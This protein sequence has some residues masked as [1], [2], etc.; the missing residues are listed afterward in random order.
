MHNPHDTRIKTYKGT[1][2]NCTK[3]KTRRCCDIKNARKRESTCGCDSKKRKI[4]QA[5]NI[6]RCTKR[7]LKIFLQRD[8]PAGI[9]PVRTKSANKLCMPE[10]SFWKSHS[11]KPHAE[12]E[13]GKLQFQNL[14]TNIN[15][16]SQIINFMLNKSGN[17]RGKDKWK[18]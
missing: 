8:E 4:F 9:N 1:I 11:W 5:K 13:P 7:T 17:T 3:K 15:I 6:F 2:I 10:I 14:S 12:V 18:A 16:S